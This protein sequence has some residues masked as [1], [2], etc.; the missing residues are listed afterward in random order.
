MK[1]LKDFLTE[2]AQCQED[3]V[4]PTPEELALMATATPLKEGMTGYA[5]EDIDPPTVLVMHRKAIRQLAEG[6]RVGIYYVDKINKYVTVPYDA[7]IP[8]AEETVIDQLKKAADTKKNI[9]V[10]HYDGT[11]SEVTPA[12][13]RRMI[14]L[15]KKINEANKAKMLEMLEASAKH[16]QTIAKFSKE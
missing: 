11:S 8:V 5:H 4:V 15:Y 6:Q 16:F 9:M 12:M 2:K 14:D 10:E 13:A 3:A 7:V 1:S